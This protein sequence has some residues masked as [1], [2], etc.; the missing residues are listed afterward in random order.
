MGLISWRNTW[1]FPLDSDDVMA[2]V[3]GEEP[4]W[5]VDGW[6]IG[7]ASMETVLPFLVDL[8]G[9]LLSISLDMMACHSSRCGKKPSF[10]APFHPKPPYGEPNL[11]KVSASAWIKYPS[12]GSPP[13]SS[14]LR[15]RLQ[16]NWRWRA[17]CCGFCCEDK[18]EENRNH[19]FLFP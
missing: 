10:G 11:P 2:E 16:Q 6:C 15:P 13:V 8:G 7:M 5:H 14:G 3:A 1:V 18:E 19:S 9:H 4:N 17:W 12:S